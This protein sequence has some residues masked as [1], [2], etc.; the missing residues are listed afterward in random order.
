MADNQFI[1][2]LLVT[3]LVKAIDSKV[4]GRD[5]G[6]KGDTELDKLL[7][8]KISERVQR[9]NVTKLLLEIGEGF[10]EEDLMAYCDKLR[11]YANELQNSIGGN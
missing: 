5:I 6:R 1:K 8:D 3:F 7:G 11:K 9:G 4:D 10:Y 2:G